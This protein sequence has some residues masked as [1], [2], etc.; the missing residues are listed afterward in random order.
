MATRQEKGLYGDRKTCGV[1]KDASGSRD[2][3]PTPSIPCS[4]IPRRLLVLDLIVAIKAAFLP[5]SLR[6]VTEY[7]ITKKTA[8]VRGSL[9]TCPIRP[10]GTN[11]R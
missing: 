5:S 2:Y 1:L 4:L 3:L 9:I 6:F 8:S 10:A 11:D 7:E